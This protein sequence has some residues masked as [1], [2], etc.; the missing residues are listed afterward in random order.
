MVKIKSILLQCQLLLKMNA[1]TVMVG[2]LK[3]HN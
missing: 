3:K 1:I 2:E